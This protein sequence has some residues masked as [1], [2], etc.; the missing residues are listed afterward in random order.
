MSRRRLS[1]GGR[2]FGLTEPVEVAPLGWRGQLAAAALGLSV[3]A[4]LV[5]ALV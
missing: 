1:R 3:F 4:A 5:V 2:T